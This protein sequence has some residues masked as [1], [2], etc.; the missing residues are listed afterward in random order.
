MIARIH[1]HRNDYEA[2]KPF[3]T[4]YEAIVNKDTAIISID[5]DELVLAREALRLQEQEDFNSFCA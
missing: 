3:M 5:P 2:L 1:L 4:G